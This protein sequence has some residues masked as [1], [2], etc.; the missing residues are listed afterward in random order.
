GRKV[1]GTTLTATEGSSAATRPLLYSAMPQRSSQLVTMLTQASIGRL[2]HCGRDGSTGENRGAIRGKRRRAA[3]CITCK[4]GG[5]RRYAGAW[6]RQAG[7][8]GTPARIVPIQT[9]GQGCPRSQ[10]DAPRRVVDTVR[11]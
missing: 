9:S 8:A 4:G 7:S 3:S 6:E 10:P 2:Y 1:A 11:G 5:T